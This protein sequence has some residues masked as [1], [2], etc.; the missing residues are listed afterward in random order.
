MQNVFTLS[1]IR[2]G[3]L[4]LTIMC[5]TVGIQA[6]SPYQINDPKPEENSPKLIGTESKFFADIDTVNQRLY[7]LIY[8]K[9]WA[10]NLREEEWDLLHTFEEEKMNKLLSE[11]KEFGYDHVSGD[12]LLWSTGV[13]LVCRIDLENYTINRIDRSFPHKNQFGHIPFFR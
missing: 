2:S 6:R 11:P 7:V 4:L 1:A 8:E 13:G 3:L 9:L 12:I 5:S 10:Y